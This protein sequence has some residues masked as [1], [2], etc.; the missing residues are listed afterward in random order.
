MG[1][2]RLC[3][4]TGKVQKQKIYCL[5]FKRQ[6]CCW[7]FLS[8]KSYSV[9][10]L[11]SLETHFSYLPTQSWRAL[12]P[13][14]TTDVKYN[15][16]DLIHTRP[17]FHC[18]AQCPCMLSSIPHSLP[19]RLSTKCILCFQILLPFM[20]AGLS[21]PFPVD[22]IQQKWGH[23]AVESCHIEASSLSHFKENRTFVPQRHSYSPAERHTGK[24]SRLPTYTN[25]RSWANNHVLPIKLANQN[26]DML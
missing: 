3:K 21:N 2:W 11:I 13:E 22:K 18:S 7:H 9:F 15:L 6:A 4:G 10:S 16:C 12:R 8:Q 24:A 19:W 14:S 1:K 5:K 20:W 26:V 25:K 17:S 23:V